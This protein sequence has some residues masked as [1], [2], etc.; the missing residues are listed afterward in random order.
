MKVRV[1]RCNEFDGGTGPKRLSAS[2]AG[3]RIRADHEMNMVRSVNG[4]EHCWRHEISRGL[5]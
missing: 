5:E 1:A 2:S 4:S 3:E